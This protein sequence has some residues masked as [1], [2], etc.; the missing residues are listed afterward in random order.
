MS[1]LNEK[2]NES[3]KQTAELG[4]WRSSLLQCGWDHLRRYVE[5]AAHPIVGEGE[6][7][8]LPRKLSGS[9]V[10]DRASSRAALGLQRGRGSSGTGPS[11]PPSPHPQRS[12]CR[13]CS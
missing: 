11:G 10:T 5:V 1:L 3:G 12:G 9:T 4:A 2:T 6:E 7:L 8:V 13:R